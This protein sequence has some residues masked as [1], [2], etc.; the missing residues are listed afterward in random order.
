[1]AAGAMTLALLLATPMLLRT[2]A[3]TRQEFTL[4]LQPGRMLG[5]LQLLLT[6]AMG[7][8][9]EAQEKNI[10]ILGAV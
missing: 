9:M 2:S 1:M 6:T 7:M 5:P 4:L 8:A 10:M 3:P